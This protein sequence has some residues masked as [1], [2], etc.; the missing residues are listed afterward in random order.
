[1]WECALRSSI[2]LGETIAISVSREVCRQRAW[3]RFL[4]RLLSMRIPPSTTTRQSSLPL[5]RT[6]DNPDGLRSPFP[7]RHG[8]QRRPRRTDRTT[9]RHETTRP[10]RYHCRFCHCDCGATSNL[11]VLRFLFRLSCRRISFV[12]AAAS[13]RCS[14]WHVW[15]VTALHPSSGKYRT[16]GFSATPVFVGVEASLCLPTAMSVVAG[17]V[18]TSGDVVK[19][20]AITV[21][22]KTAAAR[23][24][25]LTAGTPQE[26]TACHRGFRS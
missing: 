16:R 12:V 3:C 9:E 2:P 8:K 5:L 25:S 26:A 15:P 18:W 1:M 23:C 22:A 6:I 13:K 4:R 10:G 19:S 7:D 11:R 21:S 17:R 20:R 14:S 24:L